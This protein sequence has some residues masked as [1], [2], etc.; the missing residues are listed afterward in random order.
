LEQ[1]VGAK[2]LEVLATTLDNRI[3]AALFTSDD[4]SLIGDVIKRSALNGVLKFTGKSNYESGDIQRAVQRG[5]DGDCTD[6]MKLDLDI[7][8]EFEEWDK[9]FVARIETEEYVG[10]QAKVM[11]MK[12]ALALEGNTVNVAEPQHRFLFVLWHYAAVQS[13]KRAAETFELAKPKLL[14]LCISLEIRSS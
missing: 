10:T 14:A 2:I 6:N 4:K 9:Q 1:K 5:Q 12:I 8:A 11:D 13:G 3:V 7:D